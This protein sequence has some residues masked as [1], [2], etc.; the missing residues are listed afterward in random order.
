M[1]RRTW[2]IAGAVVLCWWLLQHFGVTGMT[3]IDYQG[4]KIKLSKSYASYEDYK[5]D[6]DNILPSETALVQKL[7][8]EAPIEH[9]FVSKRLM[10]QGAG[11][12][13]FPGYGMS[14]ARTHPAADGSELAVVVIE[15]PRADMDRFL[16]FR[17]RGQACEL[18]DDFVYPTFPGVIDVREENGLFVYSSENGNQVLRR[19]AADHPAQ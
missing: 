13:V 6:P 11:E 8:K 3:E 9:M 10:F 19:R 2:I 5:D 12:I 1:D 4:R 18:V 15:I 7:V 17:V 16:V 14:G